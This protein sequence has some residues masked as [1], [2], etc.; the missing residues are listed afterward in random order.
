M[1]SSDLQNSQKALHGYYSG[2]VDKALMEQKVAAEAEFRK[3]VDED[4]RLQ[5]KYADAWTKLEDIAREQNELQPKLDLQR[6]YNSPILARALNIV[7]ALDPDSA[8]PEAPRK[9]ALEPLPKKRRYADDLFAAHLERGRKWL[10]VN[11]PF[12]KVVIAELPGVEAVKR[13][14]KSGVVN[15][16]FVRK[17]LDAGL[18]KLDSWD[19]IALRTARVLRPLRRANLDKNSEF[20]AKIRVQG[21]RIGQALFEVYGSK[22]SPDA[23]FTLRFSDGVVKGFPYNGTIAPHETTFYGL[24][25][26]N[27]AFDNKWPFNLPQIWSDRRDKID[28]AKPVNFVATNDIIGGNSGSPVVNKDLEVVGLI[29][30]GNIE[31][32]PN[33]F[34]YKDDVPRSVSVHVVGIMEALKKVYD[35][36]RVVAEL[37]GK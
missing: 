30:D 36:E 5:A 8:N 23:T 9:A 4:E 28:L 21:T 27:C 24:F 14:N 33:N 1:C 17:V 20:Q 37:E 18:E 13:M 6:D 25:G 26:R 32:L 16:D 2:L 11:D 15:D 22:V 29:F 7:A 3:R 19:D 10:G 34:V 12:V 31:M 35:A